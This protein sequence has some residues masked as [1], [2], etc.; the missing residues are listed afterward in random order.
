MSRGE[1]MTKKESS[2][3]ERF[4]QVKLTSLEDLQTKVLVEKPNFIVDT[5]ICPDFYMPRVSGGSSMSMR[6]S[7]F[8]LCSHVGVRYIDYTGVYQ[9]TD[10]K[11]FLEED[12]EDRVKILPGKVWIL[13]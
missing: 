7:F 11:D 8:H 4:V 2:L 9:I 13:R 1:R 10:Q 5:R 12:F 6:S 3:R